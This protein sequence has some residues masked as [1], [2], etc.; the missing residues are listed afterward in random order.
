ME[1]AMIQGR[2]PRK[3]TCY[4][5]LGGVGQASTPP[6]DLCT[7]GSWVFVHGNTYQPLEVDCLVEWLG[8]Q[9]CGILNAW[10]V[11]NVNESAVHCVPYKVSSDIDMFHA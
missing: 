9:V 7:L 2:W 4:P 5:G 10:Y 1:H 3:V 8:H 11:V 6:G